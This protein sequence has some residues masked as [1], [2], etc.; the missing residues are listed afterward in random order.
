[1]MEETF[2]HFQDIGLALHGSSGLLCVSY[3]NIDMLMPRLLG[4]VVLCGI[5][6]TFRPLFAHVC[7][8][9]LLL[10][11]YDQTSRFRHLLTLFPCP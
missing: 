8:R 4:F 3:V 6:L 7:V 9:F 5:T 11:M 1:M 10:E 2:V